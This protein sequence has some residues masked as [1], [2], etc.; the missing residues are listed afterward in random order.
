M[1]NRSTNHG[2]NILSGVMKNANRRS[3]DFA[4]CPRCGTKLPMPNPPRC[5]K[6]RCDMKFS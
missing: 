4:H 3:M 2:L 1:S 6:W 5:P